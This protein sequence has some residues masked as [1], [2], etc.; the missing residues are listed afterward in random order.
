MLAP[1]M[2]SLTIYRDRQYLTPESK[3]LSRDFRH[4]YNAK[5]E[6]IMDFQ[7]VKSFCMW[8]TI[9]NGCLL[10]FSLIIAIT[11]LDFAYSVH[12]KLFQIPRESLNEAYYLFL[13]FY[14]IVWFVFNVVPYMALMIIGKK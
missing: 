11:G 14:K 7:K 13:G 5:M 9:L 8:C 2:P 1:D 4:T 3:A 10:V 6:A 12:G